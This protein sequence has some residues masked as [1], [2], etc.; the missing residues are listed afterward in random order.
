MPKYLCG[1]CEKAVIL[2]SGSSSHPTGINSFSSFDAKGLDVSELAELEGF[3]FESAVL[4]FVDDSV[5]NVLEV[6]LVD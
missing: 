5:A 2:I 3:S 4:S 1:N 6:V